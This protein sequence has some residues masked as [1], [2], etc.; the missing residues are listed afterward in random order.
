MSEQTTTRVA[1]EVL[2]QTG[3]DAYPELPLMVA[4]QNGDRSDHSILTLHSQAQIE[5]M[6][7]YSEATRTLAKLSCC[8][9]SLEHHL[10]NGQPVEQWQPG[11]NGIIVSHPEQPEAST[12]VTDKAG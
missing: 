12:G 7:T 10:S 3:D 6:L 1:I 11:I 5:R 9:S 2:C 8:H 4:S